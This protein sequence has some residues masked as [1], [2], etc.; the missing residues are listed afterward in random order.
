VAVAYT[1]AVLAG[2]VRGGEPVLGGEPALGGERHRPLST[3]GGTVR[4]I[5]RH[6]GLPAVVLGL[7]AAALKLA[8][9][10]LAFA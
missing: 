6:G 7:A 3:A 8:G 9:G 5:A 10:L 4:D 1:A 2:H